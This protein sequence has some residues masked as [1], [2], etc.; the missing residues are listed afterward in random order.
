MKW[1]KLF[2]SRQA[3]LDKIADHQPRLVAV[4]EQQICLVRQGDSFYA[5]SNRCTHNGESLSKGKVNFANEI[6]CPWHGYQFNLKTGR[7]Y[8]Q[9]SA[10]LETF[11][12]KIEP[13]GVYIAL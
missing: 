3:A 4:G 10:D 13:D 11:P 7:E 1:I 6:V 2:N 5:V 9:R 12:I 8:Q